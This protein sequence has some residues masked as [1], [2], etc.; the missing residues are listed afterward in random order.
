[1]KIL[2]DENMPY[3]DELFGELGQ[4]VKVSGRTLDAATVAAADVLLVRSVTKVNDALLQA[5]QQL[6]FVGSATIGMDHVDRDY[7]AS[8]NIPFANAPGC[9]AIAVGEFAFIAMLE[10]AQRYGGRLKDKRVAIVGAGNTG[11]ALA[12]CLKAYGVEYRLCDPLLAQSGD[13]REFY[14]LDELLGWADVISLHVPLT[15]EGPHPTWYLFDEQKLDKLPQN[16]WL[17]NCCRGEVIDNRALIRVKSRRADL[18]LVLD[19]WEGEPNPMAELVLLVD[20]AT[21]HIAGYSLEGKARGTYMLYQALCRELGITP[22]ADLNSLLPPFHLAGVTL[23]QNIDERQLLGLCRS[24]YDLRDD[25]WVFRREGLDGRGFDNMRKNHRHRREFSALAL[26]HT[27]ASEVDW[28]SQ[29]GFTGIG[30]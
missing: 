12:N 14:A 10:L 9:N 23:S 11:T 22:S 18:R 13:K 26:A 15:R 4:V 20:L 27:G 29:L 28:L 16:A 5:N 7:L 19:V 21:P 17:L 25:D 1:M 3:V 24:V 6:R 2:V 30:S 8:R